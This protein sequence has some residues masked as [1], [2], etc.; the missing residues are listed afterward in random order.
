MADFKECRQHAD[1][2]ARQRCVEELVLV[3]GQALDELA[4]G[5]CGNLPDA[6]DLVQQLFER[7]SRTRAGQ[8]PQHNRR[9]WLF[10]VLRHLFLDSYRK[11]ARG[12]QRVDL[13]LAV[14]PAVERE[15][16]PPWRDLASADVHDAMAMLDEPFAVAFR[17]YAIEGRSYADIASVLGLS[18][19]TV[20]TRILRARR[21]LKVVLSERLQ[22]AARAS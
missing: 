13:D 22:A 19:N 10:T 20:G 16:P 8:L 9:A 2:D 6:H 17:L 12:P 11:Q 5:L 21:K 4:L 7:V 14:L 3:Y 15:A 18:I 1:E